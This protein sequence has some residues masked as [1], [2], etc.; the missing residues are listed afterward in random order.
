M[1]FTD[2]NI[3]GV[4]VPD[5][6][7]LLFVDNNTYVKAPIV[8]QLFKGK[9][10]VKLPLAE[11]GNRSGA[12]FG[13]LVDQIQQ[14]DPIANTQM[15]TASKDVHEVGEETVD[16][17]RTR[18]Y[19]GTY[20][21]QDALAKLDAKQRAQLEQGLADSK[22]KKMSFDLWIDSEQLPRKLVLKAPLTRR[23]R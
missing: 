9:Q 2:I 20:S 18:H 16:G 4:P 15:L 19:K 1:S 10:W 7:H 23:P 3:P 22:L 13:G 14:V 11:V 8:S 17:V 5:G 6:A 12:D 21:V